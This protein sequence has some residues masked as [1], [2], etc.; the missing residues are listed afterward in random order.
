MGYIGSV[1]R[2][3][4]GIS[5]FFFVLALHELRE[6]LTKAAWIGGRIALQVG[7]SIV[8]FFLVVGTRSPARSSDPSGQPLP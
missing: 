5:Q 2:L 4:G 7:E 1:A 3:I 8:P 6:L